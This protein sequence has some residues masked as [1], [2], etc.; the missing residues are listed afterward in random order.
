MRKT[1]RAVVRRHE[2]VRRVPPNASCHVC[3]FFDPRCL[4]SIGPY[5]RCYR[6]GQLTRGRGVFEDHHIL[7][8]RVHPQSAPI[9]VNLHRIVT[10]IR[11]DLP[12]NVLFPAAA[13][14]MA[15]ALAVVWSHY[16]VDQAVRAV[17]EGSP[18]PGLMRRVFA[19]WMRTGG[20]GNKFGLP[21]R[22]P[23]LEP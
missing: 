3:G 17:I 13:D 5:W 21:L 8:R 20:V 15:L 2:L 4:Q 23:D 12:D 14:P 19:E 22:L 18:D 10:V 16:N 9:E 1:L 7:G 6:C 11:M